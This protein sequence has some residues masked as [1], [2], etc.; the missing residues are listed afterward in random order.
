[1]VTTDST[2]ADDRYLAV[3]DSPEFKTLRR[4]SNRFIAWASIIF[5]GWWLAVVVLAAFVPQF[6]RQSL[7]GPMNVGLLFVL[8]S[9]MLVVAVAVV[10][11]RYA[12]TRLDPLAEQI[13]ADAEGDA[14]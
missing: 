12:R 11:L 4:S 6:F 9:Q 8:L 7:G 13:R 14:R 1:M 3:Y 2:M 5:Y 10:Y